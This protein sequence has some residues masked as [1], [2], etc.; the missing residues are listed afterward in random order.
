VAPP[1][2]LG[3]RGQR[4]QPRLPTSRIAVRDVIQDHAAIAA[5][6]A[7]RFASWRQSAMARWLL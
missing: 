7:S 4:A 2:A 1:V 5:N 6:T 3:C